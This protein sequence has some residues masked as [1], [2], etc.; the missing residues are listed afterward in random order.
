MAPASCLP[1]SSA[2]MF[3]GSDSCNGQLAG[4]Q[5]CTVQVIFAPTSP[6]AQSGVLT[7]YDAIRTQT[8]LLSGT[9]LSAPAISVNPSSV[10]FAAQ[11]VGMAGV[12]STLTV[13][14]TG[15]APMG[16]MGFQIIGQAAGSFSCGTN[17]CSATTCPTRI[18]ATLAVGASCT[19]QVTFNPTTAGGLSAS[20]VLSSSTPGV[21]PV[22]VPLG[23]TGQVQ[24]GLTVNPTQL[25][26]GVVSPGQSSLGQTVNI[27]NTSAN[28]VTGLTVG[29]AGQG[30]PLPF[31]ISQNSCG[32]SL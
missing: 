12:P 10:N 13:T 21:T 14:S 5:S 9:G 7:F 1:Q 19:V 27:T 31:A 15:G 6:G 22:S 29:V 4:G 20:L 8:V 16:D 11:Q 24:S 28:T 30:V 23:G 26:F 17:P 2:G 18:L 32:A 3:T 25:D